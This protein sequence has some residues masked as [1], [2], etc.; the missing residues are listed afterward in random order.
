[1]KKSIIISFHLQLVLG[2]LLEIL[3]LCKYLVSQGPFYMIIHEIEFCKWCKRNRWISNLK[4][5]EALE[6]MTK[7]NC[8]KS[9]SQ[10]YKIVCL[11]VQTIF[12]FRREI[13]TCSSRFSFKSM[14]HHFESS[15]RGTFGKQ[16]GHKL[17][18]TPTLE[19]DSKLLEE[20]T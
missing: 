19:F 16:S 13:Y 12:I 9:L 1:M 5:I 18:S 7:K 2:T 14:Y 15:G 20:N 6:M 4:C 3:V 17:K 8:R 10:W 11:I